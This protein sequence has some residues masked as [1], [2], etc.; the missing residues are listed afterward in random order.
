MKKILLT[1]PGIL[2]SV[3]GGGMF[4]C[5][6]YGAITDEFQP[7]HVYL[8]L[9]FSFCVILAL[10]IV[11]IYHGHKKN[12]RSKRSIKVKHFIKNSKQQTKQDLFSIPCEYDGYD[13][14]FE[15]GTTDVKLYE[16]FNEMITD[17]RYDINILPEYHALLD[18]RDEEHFDTFYDCWIRELEKNDFVFSLDNSVEIEQFIKGI[19]RMLLRIGSGKQLDEVMVTSGYQNELMNYSLYGNNI[20]SKVNYDILEANI[21]AAELREIGYELICLFN[22]FDN[23]IKAIISLDKIVELKGIEAKIK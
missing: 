17:R 8:S 20:T 9:F 18:H 2:L 19:N 23:N 11:M 3:F 16:V 12:V 7:I 10:G 4:V 21:V 14:V 6:M 5:C 15:E 13:M 1:A 22:G